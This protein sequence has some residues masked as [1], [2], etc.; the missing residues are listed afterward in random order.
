MST[1]LITRNTEKN[2]TL[3]FSFST[4]RTE[5]LADIRQNQVP[6]ILGGVGPMHSFLQL[7]QGLKDLFMMPVEQYHKDGRILR[8]FQKGAHSFTSSTAMSF[9][10]FTN[11]LLG[12]IK[13]AAEMAFDI[14]SPET[15]IIQGKIPH[16]NIN[17]NAIRRPADM[18][19]GMFN[20]FAI[21]QEGMEETARTVIQNVIEDHSRRGNENVIWCEFW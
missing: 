7:V 1:H 6:R 15:S 4:F 9:L 14:M 17:R 13:F 11:K 20:A 19:E 8:G 10:D 2:I 12:V 18:R 5:W 3:I 16:N 21:I